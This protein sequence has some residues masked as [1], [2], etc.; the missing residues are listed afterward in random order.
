MIS[1]KEA[2]Q[3]SLHREERPLGMK[4]ALQLRI[5]LL[6]CRFCRAFVR[7]SRWINQVVGKL[8][9]TE[10]EPLSEGEKQSMQQKIIDAGKTDSE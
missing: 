3:L 4:Q 9:M 10:T 2:G 7:Q 8:D 1:C 6:I 5:H